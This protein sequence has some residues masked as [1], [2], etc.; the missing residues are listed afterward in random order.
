MIAKFEGKDAF[1]SNFASSPINYEGITYPTVEHAFQ[2]AKTL[3]TEERATIAAMATPGQAKRAGRRVSLRSDWETVKFSVMEE[4]LR[5]KFADPVLRK[6]LLNTGD[7]VLVEGN[8]WHD[9][10]WGSCTCPNCGNRGGNALGQMLM[11]IREELR[12]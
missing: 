6:K 7:L 12:Q 4:C 10:I 5:L 3:S 9:N 8:T 2:A 11:S 1:L